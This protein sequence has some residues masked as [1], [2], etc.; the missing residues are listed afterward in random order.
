MQP[1]AGKSATE[2]YPTLKP[3]H[4]YKGPA[5]GDHVRTYRRFG[6]TQPHC[7]R[8]TEPN[9]SASRSSRPTLTRIPWP[10][11]RAFSS[12]RPSTAR[13]VR[14]NSKPT[15]RTERNSEVGADRAMNNSTAMPRYTAP[16]RRP[17]SRPAGWASIRHRFSSRVPADNHPRPRIR[18]A[19]AVAIATTAKLI[20]CSSLAPFGRSHADAQTNSFELSNS[21]TML[22]RWQYSPTPGNER[23]QVEIGWPGGANFAPPNRP[24]AMDSFWPIADVLSAS[25]VAKTRSPAGTAA[26]GPSFSR[27]PSRPSR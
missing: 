17:T 8:S 21:S 20:A 25:A 22:E 19:I 26:I 10:A 14:E 6:K 9:P 12:N 23:T 2:D 24:V 18:L 3:S 16:R 27:R 11:R 4:A 13:S 5:D 7:V 15:H 1:H